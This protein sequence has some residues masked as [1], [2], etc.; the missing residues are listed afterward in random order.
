MYYGSSVENDMDL[1]Q[2]VIMFR[3]IFLEGMFRPDGSIKDFLEILLKQYQEFGGKIRLQA[4]VAR[5]IHQD[6][7]VTGVELT[8]GEVIACDALLS[9]I[10]H[11]ETLACLAVPAC[12]KQRPRL[13]F[14][15]SIFRLPARLSEKSSP[16]QNYYFLQHER[17][18]PLS[19][20]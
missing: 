15:E 9:T 18:I 2:F 8:D 7:K 16:G 4:P 1:G 6:R 10:G 14:V 13:G 11:E 19:A 5:I 20:A 12:A 3:A 17:E